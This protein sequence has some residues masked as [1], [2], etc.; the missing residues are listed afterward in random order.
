MSFSFQTILA[1]KCK[2]LD[3][4]KGVELNCQ[5]EDNGYT[6]SKG[7]T[8]PIDQNSGMKLVVDSGSSEDG[9]E[10]A[11]NADTLPIEPTYH[12]ALLSDP[13]DQFIKVAIQPDNNE[14]KGV[15]K[16]RIIVP[17]KNKHAF[18]TIPVDMHPKR[19]PLKGT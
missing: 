16:R 14:V 5:G 17:R 15:A 2:D 18:Q 6:P 10:A 1:D 4:G 7:V 3:S 13:E 9:K 8:S 11:I 19:F 12:S